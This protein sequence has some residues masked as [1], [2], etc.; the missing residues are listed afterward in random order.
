[1]G[2]H[3]LGSGAKG[4]VPPLVRVL[5]AQGGGPPLCRSLVLDLAA[6]VCVGAPWVLRELTSLQSCSVLAFK[7]PSTREHGLY[8][9]LLSLIRDCAQLV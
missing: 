1:M 4:E 6:A 5:D 7:A 9:I 8:D 3:A 2:P